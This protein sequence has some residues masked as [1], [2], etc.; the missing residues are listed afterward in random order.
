MAEMNPGRKALLLVRVTE[1]GKG[2][3]LGTSNIPKSPSHS[4][5]ASQIQTI[6][7]ADANPRLPGPG[8]WVR[9]PYIVQLQIPPVPRSDLP[10]IHPCSTQKHAYPSPFYPY[11]LSQSLCLP[12]H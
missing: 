1:F 5:G 12:A 11:N 7:S 8:L 10:F 2:S 3:S 6:Y 4:Y 9:I